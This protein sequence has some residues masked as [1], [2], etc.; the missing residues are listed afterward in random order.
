MRRP[1]YR[2]VTVHRK[3]PRNKDGDTVYAVIGVHSRVSL[4]Q[5]T[6]SEATESGRAERIVGS[7]TLV[8]PPEADIR[9]SDRLA[10][11]PDGLVL[12]VDGRPHRPEFRSGRRT[13]LIVRAQEVTSA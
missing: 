7:F 5:T 4:Q 2:T 13:N 10:V 11:S 12:S 9:A 1:G 8:F 6:T 3:G